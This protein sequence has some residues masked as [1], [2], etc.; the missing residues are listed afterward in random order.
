VSDEFEAVVAKAVARAAKERYATGGELLLALNALELGRRPSVEAA[1]SMA[2]PHPTVVQTQLASGQHTQTPAPTI[3]PLRDTESV[4]K[5]KS[6]MAVALG[7]AGTLA[8]VGVV[9]AL[10][11]GAGAKQPL[12]PPQT[13]PPNQP[14]AQSGGPMGSDTP[15]PP[16]AP[17]GHGGAGSAAT[18]VDGEPMGPQSTIVRM[19]PSGREREGLTAPDA[20][21]APAGPVDADAAK[22]LARE[23]ESLMNRGQM[24]GA[25]AA[26]EKAIAADPELADGYLMKGA[27][28]QETGKWEAGAEMFNECVRRA[29]TGRK[30]ECR[31]MGGKP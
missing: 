11:Q 15:A 3:P 24:E 5:P 18:N 1:A 26:A 9:V 28:L 29:K 22:K 8:A 14:G 10:A 4:T 16:R 27:A 17:R 13:R 12:P 19:P 30:G 31:S 6:G 23:A 25:I 21:A 20:S 2:K 7:V